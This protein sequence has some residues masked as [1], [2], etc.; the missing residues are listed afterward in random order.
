MASE[1]SDDKCPVSPQFGRVARYYDIL[2]R[3][4]PYE[5]WV[6]YICDILRRHERQAHTVLDLACGTGSVGFELQRR[7][8]EVFGVDLS[9]AMIQQGRAAA[10][11]A[12][13]RL[14]LAV[15][16]AAALGLRE[17]FDLV[18][19]LYDSLNY[20]LEADK[21][22]ECFEGVRRALVPDGTFIF[23]LNTIRALKVG[24]F[25]QDNLR[26][27]A[28]LTYDWRSQWDAKKSICRVDMWFRWRAGGREEEFQEV[29]CQRGYRPS[30]VKGLLKAAGLEVLATYNAYTMR[31]PTAWS[32]R[33]FFVAKRPA[34]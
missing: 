11:K 25:T 16:D 30:E 9:E 21:L 6:D 23:D 32:N 7:G 12:G 33:I 19:S 27:G 1:R 15:M 20:I 8:F 18:V 22:R 14:P 5:R 29:H 34:S 13:R 17:H 28:P 24:L 2:M 4:V 3:G 26:S 31:R 10:R